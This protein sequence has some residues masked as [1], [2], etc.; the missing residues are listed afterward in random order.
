[1]GWTTD[2]TAPTPQEVYDQ[3]K[4]KW[5]RLGVTQP[6]DL[7]EAVEDAIGYVTWITGRYFDDF[8]P[9]TIQDQTAI[10]PSTGFPW[11]YPFGF[12]EPVSSPYTPVAFALAPELIR[13]G[14]RCVRMRVEQTIYQDQPGYVDTA[15]D[16]VVQSF[17]AGPYSETRAQT[18]TLRGGRTSTHLLINSHPGINDM[19]MQLMTDQRREYWNMVIQG[20][21]L[22]AFM[23]EEVDWSMVGK[24]PLFP[25]MADH[26]SSGPVWWE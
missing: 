22:P 2:T 4:L 23:T 21:Y 15:T 24:S 25:S 14:K 10:N 8:V 13:M 3:S 17:T 20:A 16:D 19:L 18:S 26:S 5:A 11:G 9:A 6:S 12:D 7:D 1:V